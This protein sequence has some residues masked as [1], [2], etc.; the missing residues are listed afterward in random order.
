MFRI[1]ML[2]FNFRSKIAIH[3]TDLEMESLLIA[4]CLHRII[5]FRLNSLRMQSC[6]LLDLQLQ[7]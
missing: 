1:K 6:L 2:L 5:Q 3:C 7:M 4:P